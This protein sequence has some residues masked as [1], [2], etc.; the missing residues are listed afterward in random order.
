MK[1]DNSHPDESEWMP[2]LY[3]ECSEP[4]RGILQKHLDH[5]SACSERIVAW[6]QVQQSLDRWSL[7]HNDSGSRLLPAAEQTESLASDKRTR[8][9]ASGFS[10]PGSPLRKSRWH[11]VMAAAGSAAL[12]L[13][14]FL[15]GLQVSSVRPEDLSRIRAEISSEVR[16]SVINDL[17]QELESHVRRIT[18]DSATLTPLIESQ[19]ERIIAARLASLPQQEAGTEERR[20]NMQLLSEILTNQVELRNDLENLAVEAESQIIRTQRELARLVIGTR[21]MDSGGTPMTPESNEIEN[22]NAPSL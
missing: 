10:S 11:I 20:K 22:T 3:G 16:R 13:L 1:Q 8:V 19:S 21:M 7:A 12:I 2:Y 9:T 6:R 5:C 17:R 4:E 15:T 18:A 14:S